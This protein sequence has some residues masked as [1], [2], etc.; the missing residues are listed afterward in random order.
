MAR[1]ALLRGTGLSRNGTE[2]AYLEANASA[3]GFGRDGLRRRKLT[4][5]SAAP[6]T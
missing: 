4:K 3:L 6:A 5:G 2:E 1:R